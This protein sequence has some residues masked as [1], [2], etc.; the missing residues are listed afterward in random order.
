MQT[1]SKP[2]LNRPLTVSR[3]MCLCAT[4]AAAVAGSWLASSATAAMTDLTGSITNPSF[5]TPTLADGDY[6]GTITG[7][8]QWAD[9]GSGFAVVVNPGADS[10]PG[11]S[12]AQGSNILGIYARS[13][14][15]VHYVVYQTTSEAL[16][17]GTTYTLTV[18]VGNR[19]SGNVTD[20]FN[21][22][23]LAHGASG[24]SGLAGYNGL[25]SSLTAG[26]WTDETVSYMATAA[27]AGKTLAI[28]LGVNTAAITHPQQVTD[29]DNVRLTALVPE[30]GMISL[31][32]A[33][34]LA[35]AWRR[36]RSACQP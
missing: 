29:F 24:Y 34:G 1:T 31:L 5:E 16:V 8:T 25:G 7:W 32:A 13:D 17:P 4:L 21:I 2:T 23:L 22:E 6:T 20:N 18:A 11:G 15:G 30:P 10:Y 14:S 26:S 35:C 33:G 9:T 19:F 27:D 36:R 28:F 3:K 12:A